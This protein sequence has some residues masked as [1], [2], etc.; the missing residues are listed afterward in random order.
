VM[1]HCGEEVVRLN[2]RDSV[3]FSGGTA[4]VYYGLDVM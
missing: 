2:Y 4:I 3:I 1:M